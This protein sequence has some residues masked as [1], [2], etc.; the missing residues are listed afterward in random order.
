MED[1]SVES[2]AVPT[3][4]DSG[5]STRGCSGGACVTEEAGGASGSG[6]KGDVG[7]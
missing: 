4:S 2:F 7:G 6:F 1:A 5:E 3:L